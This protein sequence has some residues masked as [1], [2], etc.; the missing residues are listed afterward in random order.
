[1]Q[2]AIKLPQPELKELYLNSKYDIIEQYMNK[3]CFDK[4]KWEDLFLLIALGHYNVSQT[5]L[6]N[7]LGEYAKLTGQKFVTLDSFLIDYNDKL[8]FRLHKRISFMKPEAYKFLFN[9]KETQP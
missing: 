5:H 8:Y 9:G 4:Q 3:K 7:K 6:Q 1:M 2:A